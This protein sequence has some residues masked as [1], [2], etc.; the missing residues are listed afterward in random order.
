MTAEVPLRVKMVSG[1]PVPE[2]PGECEPHTPSPDGYLQ[3][4]AWCEEMSRT[5]V[6]RQCKGCGLWAIWEPVNDSAA[7]AAPGED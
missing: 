5:H 7:T 6:Q 4:D 1:H 2:H 3:Y